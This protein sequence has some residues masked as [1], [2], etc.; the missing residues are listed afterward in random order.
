MIGTYV[1]SSGY[2][3]AYYAKAQQVRHLIRD[4]FQKAFTEVDVIASP[5]TP[6][7]A[8]GLGA[9]KDPVSMYLSDIYTIAVNLA[10]L[11]SM[12]LPVGFSQQLP[13]GM[14]LIGNFLQESRMLN[15][16]HQYQQVT[17]WHRKIPEEYK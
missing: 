12:S 4:D 2:Y 1:L 14:Q 15:V 8:F 7:T 17:D 6:T 3:D 11:P 13:I 16:A 5:A 10:G 9:K